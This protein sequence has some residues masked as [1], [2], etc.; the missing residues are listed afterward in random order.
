VLHNALC[1]SA[2]TGMGLVKL[3]DAVLEKYHGGTVIVQVTS[4][5]SNGKVQSFLRANAV[6]ISE[7]YIDS[8]TIIEAQIGKNQLGRLKRLGAEAVTIL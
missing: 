1:I 5:Q 2:K 3:H 6:I 4:P 7:K 8:S